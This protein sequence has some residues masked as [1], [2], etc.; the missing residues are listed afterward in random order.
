MAENY[1]VEPTRSCMQLCDVGEWLTHQ[2]GCFIDMQVPV[3]FIY[4]EHDCKWLRTR[5]HPAIQ[6]IRPSG[7]CVNEAPFGSY[8]AGSC[9]SLSCTLSPLTS[10]AP[11]TGHHWQHYPAAAHDVAAASIRT[12][13]R[14]VNAGTSLNSGLQQVYA[15]MQGV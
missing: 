9:Y 14:S 4:G 12:H 8:L 5:L 2:S 11:L 10:L 7:M 13:A 3:T 15:R 6:L 1:P